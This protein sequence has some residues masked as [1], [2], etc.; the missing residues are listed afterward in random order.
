MAS[1][2]APSVRKLYRELL[3]YAS[4]EGQRAEVRSGFRSALENGETIESRLKAAQ[5][6]LAFLRISSVMPRRKTA[7]ESSGKWIY[8]NGERLE[9]VGGTIRDAAG[10]VVSSYDGS[11]LDPESVSRHRKNLKRAGFV[12][13]LHAKGFF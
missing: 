2:A 8:K 6:K 10:R 5:D 3:S 7:G 4:N 1:K 12:N 13:N 11:N 9:N